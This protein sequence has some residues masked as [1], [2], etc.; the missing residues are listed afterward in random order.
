MDLAPINFDANRPFAV[1]AF[2]GCRGSGFDIS[3]AIS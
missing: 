3:S 2:G 1:V